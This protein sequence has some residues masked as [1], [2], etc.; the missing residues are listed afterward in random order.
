MRLV[1]RTYWE[2]TSSIWQRCSSRCQRLSSGF[3]QAI[4]MRRGP[5]DCCTQQG[6]SVPSSSQLRA[7]GS[8][9]SD[10]TEGQLFWRRWGVAIALAGLMH[11]LLL[12]LVFLALAGASDMVSGLFRPAIWNQTIP[13][14]VRGRLAGIELLSYSFGPLAGQLRTASVASVTS[15]SFSVTFGGLICVFAVILLARFRPKLQNYDVETNKFAVE[16][17]RIRNSNS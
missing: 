2:Y 11:S 1:A 6:L 16:Q 17:R 14:E 5:L 4:F 12:V 10:S 13:N 9:P 7:V 15:S 8:T 3:G